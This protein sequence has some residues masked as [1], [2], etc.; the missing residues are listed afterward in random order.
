MIVSRTFYDRYVEFP[1]ADKVPL[2]IRN[3]PDYFPFFVGCLG[4]VVG[5][6]IESFVASEDIPRYRNRK[7][8]IPDNMYL[9]PI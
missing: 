1:P 9:R 4:A 8:G 5:T 6:H 2:R 3:D 7:G